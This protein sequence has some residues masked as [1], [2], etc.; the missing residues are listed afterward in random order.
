MM[1]SYLVINLLG[2]I[3]NKFKSN[4]KLSDNDDF[5]L[6]NT[7][8]KKPGPSDPDMVKFMADLNR[9]IEE[10]KEIEKVRNE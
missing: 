4:N 8:P 5:Y 3:Q 6:M 2:F 9:S 7:S 1:A 10:K